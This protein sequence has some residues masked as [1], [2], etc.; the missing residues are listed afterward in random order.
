MSVSKNGKSWWTGRKMFLSTA[1]GEDLECEEHR[2]DD[3]S[4]CWVATQHGKIDRCHCHGECSG[5]NWSEST[6]KNHGGYSLSL[7]YFL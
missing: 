3:P 7:K 2:R 1:K 6:M 5:M 4:E